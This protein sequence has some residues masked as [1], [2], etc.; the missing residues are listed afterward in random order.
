MKIVLQVCAKA[1]L[2]LPH[3]TVESYVCHT[4]LIFEPGREAGLAH[5]GKSSLL[6]RIH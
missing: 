1:D 6:C 3:D 4:C 2:M 5:L